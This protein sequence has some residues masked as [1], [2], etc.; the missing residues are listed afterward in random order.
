[1][2]EDL[3]DGLFDEF[4]DQVRD[5]NE[6]MRKYLL[7]EP[8]HYIIGIVQKEQVLSS[9]RSRLNIDPFTLTGMSPNEGFIKRL[10]LFTM[11]I[12]ARKIPVHVS[13]SAA[14]KRLISMFK[15]TVDPE[16][17]DYGTMDV[18]KY[19]T[20][21]LRDLLLQVQ[22]MTPLVDID[23]SI[24][25]ILELLI[26][27]RMLTKHYAYKLVQ[28]DFVEIERIKTVLDDVRSEVDIVLRAIYDVTLDTEAYNLT[29]KC[30]V[31]IEGVIANLCGS[32]A[33][34]AYVL[35]YQIHGVPIVRIEEPDY[36][37]EWETPTN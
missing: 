13:E 25:K 3:F 1:M 35:P 2:E 10:K 12:G 7:D 21:N 28:N 20:S 31:C 11:P 9:I 29:R 32:F 30:G 5:Q 26:S 19:S 6:Q 33:P 15:G 37:T 8:L 34:S 17:L 16:L 18:S 24:D 4:R 14:G 27:Y 36:F 23:M 22:P